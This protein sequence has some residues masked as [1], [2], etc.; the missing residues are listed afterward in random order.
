MVVG[1]ITKND[2]AQVSLPGPL[3][4]IFSQ[5]EGLTRYLYKEIFTD[6]A[7]KPKNEVPAGGVVIDAGCNIGLFSMWAAMRWPSAK[8]IAFE[9]V[10]PT[11][12]CA[13][14][15]L[16]AKGARNVK[17]LRQGLSD[18]AVKDV[19]FTYYPNRPGVSTMNPVTGAKEDAWLAGLAKLAEARDTAGSD[20][21]F[22]RKNTAEKAVVKADLVRLHNVLVSEK[23]ERVDLLKIDVERCELQVLK[24]LDADDFKKVSEIIVEV[25]DQA[26]QLPIV[27]DLLKGH[28]F[29]VETQHECT[30]DGSANPWFA[31]VHA[32][33]K[34]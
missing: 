16:K 5:E 22:F 33:R 17:L 12:E 15:N 23:V 28:G 19:P 9:P 13:M 14:Q 11:W 26:T 30:K 18:V 27:V 31:G 4:E 6:G 29:E 8:V 1:T 7:Y 25:E 10:T 21:A 20:E 3:G 34:D 2:W 24:G 32:F